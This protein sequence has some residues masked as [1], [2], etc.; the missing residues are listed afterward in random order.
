MENAAAMKQVSCGKITGSTKHSA[1]ACVSVRVLLLGCTYSVCVHGV[2]QRGAVE[3][4]GGQ[5]GTK[6]TGA[7]FMGGGVQFILGLSMP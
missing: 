2:L 6:V 3:E 4:A 7:T 1:C 5:K